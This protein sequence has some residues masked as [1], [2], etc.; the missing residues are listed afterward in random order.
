MK[1]ESIRDLKTLPLKGSWGNKLT[2]L[3]TGLPLQQRTFEEMTLE[4][5]LGARREKSFY[6]GQDQDLT[7]T[8]L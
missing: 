1:P 8:L 7:L 2:Q 4:T 6:I 5:M 3:Q